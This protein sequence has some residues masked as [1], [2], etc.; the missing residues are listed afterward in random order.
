VEQ[1]RALAGAIANHPNLGH[2]FVSHCCLPDAEYESVTAAAEAEWK[3]GV[4]G[5]RYP[6]D[7]DAEEEFTA[8]RLAAGVSLPPECAR[9]ADQYRTMLRTLEIPGEWLLRYGLTSLES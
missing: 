2:H 1:F 8:S 4:E 7:F 6:D 3:R 9:L 5:G